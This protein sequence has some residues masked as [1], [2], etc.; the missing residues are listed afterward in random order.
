MAEPLTPIADVAGGLY[1]TTLEQ[2]KF[3]RQDGS[4]SNI[5]RIIQLLAAELQLMETALQEVM[6]AFDIT[7]AVGAQLDV[8]GRIAN[9]A[10]AGAVDSVYRPLVA[11]GLSAAL[12]G[13]AEQVMAQVLADG[14]TSVQYIP[15]WP[16]KF[17]LVVDGDSVVDAGL[18]AFI[19]TIS[20]AGVGGGLAS[21][22]A[23][24]DSVADLLLTEAGDWIIL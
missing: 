11:A 17:S 19:A 13:T 14:H 8:L 18:A 24:E 20:P 3:C 5:V 4:Q 21:G 1:T 23:L 10:R 9:V 15:V 7:T 2:Y 16:A 6:T 12:S 22:L